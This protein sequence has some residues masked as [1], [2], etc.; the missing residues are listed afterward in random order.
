M[1]DMSCLYSL[2][3]SALVAML[4]AAQFIEVQ[5]D[6]LVS[7]QKEG[8]KCVLPFS[9]VRNG[10]VKYRMGD[11]RKFLKEEEGEREWQ[12]QIIEN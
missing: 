9:K 11:L 12:Q 10:K 5:C 8:R 3:D 6:I 7:W 2:P 4:D 1:E